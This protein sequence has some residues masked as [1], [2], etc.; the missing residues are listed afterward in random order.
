MVRPFLDIASPAGPRA[1][2]SVLVL[3]R[4]LAQPDPLFAAC[5]QVMGIDSIEAFED[6]PVDDLA[7]LLVSVALDE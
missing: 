5:A 2:L 7:R 3:H 1:R 6:V 4:V